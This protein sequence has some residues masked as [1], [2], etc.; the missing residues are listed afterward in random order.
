MS[1]EN[2]ILQI[3]LNGHW[4]DTRSTQCLKF[5]GLFD[6]FLLETEAEGDANSAV[7]IAKIEPANI[8]DVAEVGASV[9]ARRAEPPNIG[10]SVEGF[11]F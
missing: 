6:L 3:Y 7:R 5:Y 4:I 1:T 2:T 10:L 9:V 8:V 11:D